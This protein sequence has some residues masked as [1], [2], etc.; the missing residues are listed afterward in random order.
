LPKFDVGVKFDL[1]VKHGLMSATYDTVKSEI[2]P[3]INQLIS[4]DPTIDTPAKAKN[5]TLNYYKSNGYAGYV[6]LLED[7]IEVLTSPTAFMSEV[8]NMMDVL[9]INS[10]F[11]T[12]TDVCNKVYNKYCPRL[13][14]VIDKPEH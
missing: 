2:A 9:D 10:Y 11:G 14:T 12:I 3:Y 5:Y 6:H 4:L 8:E 13:K 1:F 7:S